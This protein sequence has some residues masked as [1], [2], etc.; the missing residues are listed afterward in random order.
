MF[1]FNNNDNINNNKFIRPVLI[2]Y[3]LLAISPA[4]H[5]DTYNNIGNNSVSYI[6]P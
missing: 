6:R 5:R 1:N 2:H 3:F 4:D